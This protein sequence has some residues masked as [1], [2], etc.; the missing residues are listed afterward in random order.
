ML[1]E[2]NPVICTE[3]CVAY[4]DSTNEDLLWLWNILVENYGRKVISGHNI[5]NSN[6]NYFKEMAYFEETIGTMPAIMV[7]EM[8]DYDQAS[9][10]NGV[11]NDRIGDVSDGGGRGQGN[12]M[13]ESQ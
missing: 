12:R 11:E 6:T 1:N 3:H 8:Y 10:E 5:D 2:T 13:V 4:N 7:F 9:V